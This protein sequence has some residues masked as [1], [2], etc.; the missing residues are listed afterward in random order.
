MNHINDDSPLGQQLCQLKEVNQAVLF[1]QQIQDQA[2]Q[3]QQQTAK[4]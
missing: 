4:D 3:I 1:K 2:Q